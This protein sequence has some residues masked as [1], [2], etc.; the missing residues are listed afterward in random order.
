MKTAHTNA[1]LALIIALTLISFTSAYPAAAQN[2]QTISKKELKVLL[3]TGTEPADHRKIAAYYHQ[4]ALRL[5]NDA[6]T[7]QD[8]GD[9]YA[10]GPAGVEAKHPGLTNG[11]NHC[12]KIADLEEQA[13]KEADAL[14]AGHEDM[15]KEAEKK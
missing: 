14:A 8:W 13:A 9:I 5:R 10:Q 3:K 2:N 4:E 11:S 6:K 7:H 12:H 1:S 15:A